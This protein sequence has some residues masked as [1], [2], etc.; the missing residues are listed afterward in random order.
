L[1]ARHDECRPERFLEAF[2]GRVDWDS[3]PEAGRAA[4]SAAIS[5]VLR[6]LG[7]DSDPTK[8]REHVAPT[9]PGTSRPGNLIDSIHRRA[10]R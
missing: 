10:A 7:K 1:N 4:L 3:D 8:S 2:P 5:L 9:E 6:V